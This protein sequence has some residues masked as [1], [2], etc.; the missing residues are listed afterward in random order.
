MKLKSPD[1]RLDCVSTCCI[2]ECFLPLWERLRAFPCA[3]QQ[4]NSNR[5]NIQT[6]LSTFS[7]KHPQNSRGKTTRHLVKNCVGFQTTGCFITPV[8]RPWKHS[9]P[10]ECWLSC[11]V[12]GC[13]NYVHA[14]SRRCS[15]KIDGDGPILVALGGSFHDTRTESGLSSA[16]WR[17]C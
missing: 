4:G 10:A 3:F 5:G 7:S 8:Q 17:R 11:S 14:F 6:K 15:L 12:Q 13:S 1:S 9:P 2:L 16:C